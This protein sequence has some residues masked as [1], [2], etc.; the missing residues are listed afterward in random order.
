MTVQLHPH[1]RRFQS[2]LPREERPSLYLLGAHL[3]N[4]NPRS[5]E[6][7][8]SQQSELI[9]MLR[10]SIHAPTR[11]ATRRRAVLWR[12]IKFQSTLPREERPTWTSASLTFSAFQSTLPREE[13][14]YT[15]HQRP[16]FTDFNPRSHERSDWL[17]VSRKTASCNFN[18]RS[19]ERSDRGSAGRRQE[20]NYFN[21]RSHERSDKLKSTIDYS[22]LDFNPRSHERSD[23]YDKIFG[24]LEKISIHAP[25]R[26]ATYQTTNWTSWQ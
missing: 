19:H 22:Y 17:R 1:R 26:G 7:S 3:H 25:T 20:R 11:G 23:K 8:D 18:P 15:L 9:T 24:D 4:F 14:L 6:R 16:S 10:I 21:P 13:R 2:T 5:H 12:R